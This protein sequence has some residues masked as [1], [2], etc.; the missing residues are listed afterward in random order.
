MPIQNKKVNRFRVCVEK[1]VTDHFFQPDG[2]RNHITECDVTVL[3]LSAQFVLFQQFV[4]LSPQYLLL[5]G[6]FFAIF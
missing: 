1:A 5:A 3:T 4:Y 6:G 2:D